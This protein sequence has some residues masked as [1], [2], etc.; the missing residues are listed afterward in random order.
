LTSGGKTFS[1]EQQ[2]TAFDAFISQDPYLSEIRGEYSERNGGIAKWYNS[3]DFSVIQNINFKSGS[4][5]HTLQV[6][7]D[8]TNIG[9]LLNDSWGVLKVVNN[10]RPLSAAGTSAN[11]TPQ[12]RMATQQ[13]DGETQLL[14]DTFV[15]SIGTGSVWQ[16]QLGVRYI[17]N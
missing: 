6:R 16:A 15:P 11:G 13:I 2:A 10:G 12:F 1:P 17:F 8:I 4:T 14:R 3:V 9:N 5:K 7:A